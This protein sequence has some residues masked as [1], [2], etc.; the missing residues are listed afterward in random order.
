M[1]SE[2][3]VARCCQGQALEL[4]GGRK[5]APSCTRRSCAEVDVVRLLRC[6]AE[7]FALFGPWLQVQVLTAKSDVDGALEAQLAFLTRG[8]HRLFYLNE[9]AI[10]IDRIM[11]RSLQRKEQLQQRRDSKKERERVNSRS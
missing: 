9:E 8:G 2:Q 5:Q 6:S 7:C 3:A 1:E 4:P 10:G 11:K